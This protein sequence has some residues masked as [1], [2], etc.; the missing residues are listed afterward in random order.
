MSIRY[1][2]LIDNE[3]FSNRSQIID[4]LLKEE[5]SGEDCAWCIMLD[6]KPIVKSY[7][8]DRVKRCLDYIWDR[9]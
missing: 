5:Y 2:N 6:G 7:N 4:A 9:K 8:F 1:F 3:T